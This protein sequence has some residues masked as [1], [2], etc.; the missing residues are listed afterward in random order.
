MHQHAE[1]DP[2]VRR[3]SGFVPAVL[4]YP[5]SSEEKTR[6]PGPTRARQHFDLGS[7]G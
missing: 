3:R 1:N 2:L 4:A 7:I 6:M 5:A